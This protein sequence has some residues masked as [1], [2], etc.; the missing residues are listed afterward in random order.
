MNNIRYDMPQGHKPD[1]LTAAEPA[2]IYL[3][4]AQTG[5]FSIPQFEA[6]NRKL[7]FTQQEW[8]DILHISHRTLQRYLKDQKP[9]EGLH[10]EHLCQ[11]DALANIGQSIFSSAEAFEAWLRVPKSILDK[12]IDFAA[13]RSFGGVQLIVDELGRMAYGIYS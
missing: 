10:A 4:S 1:I 2:M 3:S 13:L 12:S 11:I 8:A 6:L 7:P 5:S 9:F